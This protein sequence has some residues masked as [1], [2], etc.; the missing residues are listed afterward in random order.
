MLTTSPARLIRRPTHNPPYRQVLARTALSVLC[1]V[2][3]VTNSG[4]DRPADATRATP[5]ASTTAT[6][7]PV[8]PD[9]VEAGP[10]RLE[11]PA[12]DFGR[13]QRASTAVAVVR[14]INISD[15]VLQIKEVKTTCGCTTASVSKEPFGPGEAIEVEVRLK[16][17][18][19]PGS[20]ANKIVRFVLEGDYDPV[21]LEVT[22]EIVEFV[23]IEPEQLERPI[24]EDQKIVIRSVDRKPFRILEI[25]PPI[26]ST[27]LAPQA[28]SSHELIV[29]TDLWSKQGWPNALTLELDHPDTA[30]VE[31]RIVRPRNNKTKTSRPRPARIAEP[32]VQ[33]ATVK[34]K[35]SRPVLQTHPRRLNFGHL[36]PTRD[37]ER[38]IRLRGVT[39]I[40]G[41]EP[42]VRSNS[43]LV[44][45]ELLHWQTS[46]DGLQLNVR[47]TPVPG[48]QG[49]VGALLVVDYGSG[50][51]FTKI[52]GRVRLDQD[53]VASER[54]RS[55]NETNRSQKKGE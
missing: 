2:Y 50:R 3:L 46:A 38:E 21:P 34:R 26:V 43:P 10:I 15:E 37:V 42:T 28:R 6:T 52:H 36:T 8:E 17:R 13:I 55:S 48:N 32:I 31:L 7:I 16:T 35:V 5:T 19:K 24:T 51:G 27:I 4:C 33:A 11:P 54:P 47:L 53:V 45:V 49:R 25:H 22:A 29:S 18:I 30:D 20:R 40:E 12:I 1:A 14:L 9:A 41:V 44:N 23:T 39:V